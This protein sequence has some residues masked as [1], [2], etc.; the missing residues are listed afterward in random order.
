MARVLCYVH[1]HVSGCSHFSSALLIR[2][3]LFSSF[4]QTSCPLSVSDVHISYLPLAHM[5]E[6][7]VQVQSRMLRVALVVGIIIIM[8]IIII[9]GN[10][11]KCIV[12]ISL[13]FFC[14]VSLS[15]WYLFTGVAS[16]ISREISAISWMT[17]W[18][19]SPLSFQLCH[20]CS[21]ECLIRLA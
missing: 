13:F 19:C 12:T 5:F 8:I 2:F 17:F 10:L 16:A 6:R 1:Y 7:I 9:F 3:L 4:F 21:T 11:W 20:V 15:A 14:F 18:P